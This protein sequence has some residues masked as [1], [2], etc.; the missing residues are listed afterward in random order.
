MSYRDKAINDPLFTC[1]LPRGHLSSCC[2]C[3]SCS[4]DLLQMCYLE[5]VIASISLKCSLIQ[6]MLITGPYVTNWRFNKKQ[7][8]SPLLHFREWRVLDSKAPKQIEKIWQELVSAVEKV[9][10]G[11]M[12][13]CIRSGCHANVAISIDGTG[14]LGR[15]IFLY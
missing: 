10:Q 6:R 8:K 7:E 2:V 4:Q 15:A 3:T 5:I 11:N 12:E 1:F 13:D 9:T 14:L